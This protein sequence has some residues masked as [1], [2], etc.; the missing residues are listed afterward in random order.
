MKLQTFSIKKKNRRKVTRSI[1][2]GMILCL[3][4]IMLLKVFFV[5]KKYKSYDVAQ[6]GT[7]QGFVALSYLGVDK[8]GSNTLISEKRLNEQLSAL[9][10]NGYVTITQQD[11][12]SY[13]QEG[14]KL[15]EKA[16]FL[17]F[18]DG[19]RD[20]SIF[21]QTIM[22][23]YNF[24][25]SMLF[26]GDKFEKDDT[27][28]L[29][30]KD[31]KELEESTFW[32]LGSNGYRLEFINIFD[33]Y[34]NYI[35]VMS[36][37][38]FTEVRS[39]LGRDYNHYL[40][41][42]IRDEYGI[43]TE[44]HEEMEERIGW[45]YEQMKEIYSNELGEVP[46]LYA[47][48]HS[49]TNRFG[50]NE[51][52]SEINE[53]WIKELFSLNFNREGMALN[54]SKDTLYNLTRLQV[55]P[56]WST[57]HLLMR[58]Y[59]GNKEGIK[60]EIGDAKKANQWEK[61]SGEVEYKEEKIILTSEPSNTGCIRLKESI[62]LN[63]VH[64]TTRLLGNKVGKQGI[65]LGNE[66]E[67]TEGI[68]I[69]INHNELVIIDVANKKELFRVNLDQVDNMKYLSK[70]ED[71]KLS[72]EQVY[73]TRI[74]YANSKDTVD[75]YVVRL[76]EVDNVEVND[77]GEGED[78][79]IPTIDVNESG[80]RFLEIMLSEDTLSIQID[81]KLVVKEVEVP[82]L[83]DTGYIFLEAGV[84]SEEKYSQ[85]NISD[86]VYDGVFNQLT[87]KYFED[88]KGGIIYED[89][90]RG[91]E[92]VKFKVANLTEQIIN[93]FIVYL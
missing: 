20:T 56:Y 1:V 64:I 36:P 47:L 14:K 90:L 49:N 35:G 93:W 79:Y 10:E 37:L 6:I 45:D 63:N 68:G 88:D 27:K 60:F 57:N 26:Y 65:Y 73:R 44:S 85:R 18:E 11:I 75:E 91:W 31:L 25:A 81:D 50:S 43:P 7:N 46:K 32:E 72:K 15:P 58:L 62:N 61:L 80:N 87:V 67:L 69:Q 84:D 17:M 13:Y 23:R 34:H 12:L 9:Y 51:A 54:T 70:E 92:G 71:E 53:K 33:R 66:R 28:F 78:V 29:M 16:L 52:V 74:K 22:E 3:I 55:Q 59:E 21:A 30:I 40:M 24:I 4:M 39:Y 42:Y 19:R 38:E 8:I 86:T 2:E 77:V 83:F 76:N 5:F 82:M 41:D 89:I 48:M